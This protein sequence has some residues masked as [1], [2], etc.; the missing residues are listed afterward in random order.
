MRIRCLCW[1]VQGFICDLP[2]AAPHDTPQDA[3]TPDTSLLHH[4][5][6]HHLHEEARGLVKEREAASRRDGGGGCWGARH[7][8]ALL[9]MIGVSFDFM[10]QTILAV[11][12]VAMV[13]QRSGG[14]EAYGD[15][16]PVPG[17]QNI[18]EQ[19]KPGEYDWNERT[20]GI[21]QGSLSYGSA[22]MSLPAGRLSEKYGGKLMLGLLVGSACSLCL[23]SPTAAY[24]SPWFLVAVRVMQGI[25]V[26]GILPAVHIVVVKWFP[27]AE[28]SKFVS[29]IYT[30][31]NLGSVTC[32]TLTGWLCG[33]DW[34]G[35]W[36]APFYV[37]GAG[38]LAWTAL[39]FLLV[40][41]TPEKHP[42]ITQKELHFILGT[43]E[44]KEG[45]E[46]EQS[47]QSKRVPWGLIL[48]TPGLWILTLTSMGDIFNMYIIFTMLPTY[49]TNIQHFSLMHAGVIA[50]VPQLLSCVVSLG[51]GCVVGRLTASHTLTTRRIRQISA[52]V[53]FGVPAACM[54]GMS[55]VGCDRNAAV[56]LLILSVCTNVF[57]FTGWM[58][59]CQDMSPVYCGTAY[60][61]L[62]I[63]NSMSGLAGPLV[64]GL[65][66]NERQTLG[67]WRSVFLTST[68]VYVFCCIIYIIF[69][70]VRQHHWDNPSSLASSSSPSSPSS[71]FCSC[72]PTKLCPKAVRVKV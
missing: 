60:G 61:F 44:R 13:G 71:S 18:T 10:V 6:H 20:Q 67:A 69:T 52:A 43:D 12:I 37:V 48:R 16:C 51:W 27:P 21:L 38:G 68:S 8:V 56:A 4:N 30:G 65:I 29:I 32:M 17:G 47:V 41:P 40:H 23:V 28:R 70:P 53:A 59:S 58:S 35:G 36:P 63:F 62:I 49:L 24:L 46:E 64:T 39:W 15:V 50:A 3:P 34:L 31:C 45:E 33:L 25:A 55:L 14:D 19:T 72:C 9:A 66:I 57:N 7:T 1:R 5:H 42:R 2:M 26:G 11:A 54:L 22:F